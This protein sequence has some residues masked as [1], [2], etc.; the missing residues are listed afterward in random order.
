EDF[1]GGIE[2]PLLQIGAEIEVYTIQGCP[3]KFRNT[4]MRQRHLL[5]GDLIRQVAGR[6]NRQWSEFH[7]L[8][9]HPEQPKKGQY[10][11]NERGTASPEQDEQTKQKVAGGQGEKNQ[12]S[13]RPVGG[14]AFQQVIMR[15]PHTRECNGG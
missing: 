10:G 7:E 9:E 5:G 8:I 6:S 11:G 3:P 4:K 15:I 2:V 14:L 1:A 12:S 13:E